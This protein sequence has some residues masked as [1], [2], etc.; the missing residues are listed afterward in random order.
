MTGGPHACGAP[1]KITIKYWL[2]HW[3]NWPEGQKICR[4]P[5]HLQRMASK[6]W[7]PFFVDM[8]GENFCDL[9]Y[10]SHSPERFFNSFL[11]NMVSNPPPPPPPASRKF[12]LGEI[13]APRKNLTVGGPQ[14]VRLR[15]WLL[16]LHRLMPDTSSPRTT[17]TLKEPS[18]PKSL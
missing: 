18:M 1:G 15:H 5:K 3:E 12:F 13:R 7:I 8:N 6:S 2:V 10:T 9:F 11:R 4:W 14:E 17:D 16:N